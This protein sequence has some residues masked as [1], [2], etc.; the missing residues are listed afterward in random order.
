[1]KNK[2]VSFGYNNIFPLP[3]MTLQESQIYHLLQAGSI[4]FE[5]QRVF[6]I[7]DRHF[8]VDFFIDDKIILECTSTS[9]KKFQVSLRQKAIQLE[10]KCSHLSKIFGY[11]V[12]ILFEAPRSIST[13]FLQTLTCLLPS[14]ERIFTSNQQFIESL[15][16]E[17][18]VAQ[19][20]PSP[21]LGDSEHLMGDNL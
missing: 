17:N 3:R 14:V 4:F 16:T 5:C 8:I 10:E 20:L 15:I 11:P 19:F 1:M 6:R 18:V 21:S 12:W 2:K 9:M 7:G 13:Q